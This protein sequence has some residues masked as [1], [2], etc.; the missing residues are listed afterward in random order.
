MATRKS[1]KYLNLLRSEAQNHYRTQ[2]SIYKK[3]SA[4][5]SA[6]NKFGDFL[7]IKVFK[8]IFHY[9]KSRFGG[10]HKFKNYA[11]SNNGVFK[12]LSISSGNSNEIKLTVASDWATDTIESDFIGERMDN[13]KADYTIH[14]GDTYYVGTPAEM[15]CNF[16]SPGNSW[17]RGK[18]GT[19]S[20]PGNHDFYSNGDGFFDKLLSKMFIKT[21]EGEYNQ[22]ASFFCLENEYW[23][24]LGLD[25]GYHS[26]GLPLIEFIFKPD[27]HL[28][29]IIINWL[30]DKVGLDD[31]D[32]K[33]GLILLT[34]HQYYSAFEDEYSKPA[35]Q[36]AK[37]IGRNRPVIWIWGHEHRFAVYGC[38]QMKEG[39]KTFGRCIGHG[40]M[41]IEIIHEKELNKLKKDRK[42]ILFDNRYKSKLQKTDIGL[43]GYSNLLFNNDNLIIEYFD[44]NKKILSEEW[45]IDLNTGLLSGK[46]ITDFTS[47]SYPS[48]LENSKDK[49]FHYSR[50]IEEA[51]KE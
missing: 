30:K 49:L 12:M 33:R 21:T 23:R 24:I 15:D 16:L 4:G 19:L 47:G 43:N 22:E 50:N 20:L 37:F 36:L 18:S 31:P 27:A 34:H 13:E 1:V 3:K 38:V 35:I 5:Q 42:L 41:P 17:P 40:G 51:I 44:E 2:D 28:N 39:I 26:V 46:K 9:V 32:D 25:T 7:T 14:L 10:K 8:W 48:T 29:P 6:I 11:G 45:N